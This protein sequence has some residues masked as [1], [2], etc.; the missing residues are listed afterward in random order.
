MQ[1]P[2]SRKRVRTKTELLVPEDHTDE[3][4]QLLEM[5]AMSVDDEVE[6]TAQEFAQYVRDDWSWKHQFTRTMRRNSTY[7]EERL[8]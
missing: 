2:T 5:L 1:Q 3:Y 7:L 4:D 6:L 8:H